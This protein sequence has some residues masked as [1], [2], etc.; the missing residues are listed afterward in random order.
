MNRRTFLTNASAATSI[1]AI[2]G[3]G[4]HKL[5]A[6][7]SGLDPNLVTAVTSNHTVVTT[8]TWNTGVP[9]P[10]DISRLGAVLVNMLNAVQSG[11]LA[12]S[13]M[14]S[15]AGV[16]INSNTVAA[17]NWNNPLA[18]IQTIEPSFSMADLQQC[19]S[20]VPLDTASLQTQ[21]S[22]LQAGGLVNHLNS[23]ISALIAIN[24]ARSGG[25]SGGTGGSQSSGCPADNLAVLAVG[26]AFLVI[27]LMA[28][29]EV[30]IMVLAA[31]FWGPLAL[32]GGIGAG[33]WGLV[34]AM[35]CG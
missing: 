24:R 31:E 21:L 4:R 35:I 17:Y 7:S 10:S 26:T 23:A 11:G 25:G 2:S 19:L 3:F 30:G 27:G 15:I 22:Q 12:T 16:T 8:D 1:A 34:H 32:W 6:Q 18:Q 9:S 13:F 33:T 29:P 5:Y 20:E 28:A 14:Q